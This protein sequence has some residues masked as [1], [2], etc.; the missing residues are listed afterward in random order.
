MPSIATT[1]GLIN[2]RERGSG[3]PVVMLHATLH[4]H[5]DFE[6]IFEEIAR[7]HRAVIALKDVVEAFELGPAIFIGNSVGGYAAAQLAIDDPERVAGLILV[8]SGGFT[9][10]SPATRAFIRLM[11]SPAFFTK[12]MLPLLARAYM[13]AKTPS[14]R[15]IIKRVKARAAGS[16]AAVAAKLWGSFLDPAFDLRESGRRYSRPTRAGRMQGRGSCPTASR[17]QQRRCRQPGP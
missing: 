5:R 10:Q 2:Y 16:G 17:Q 1:H 12:R 4:D 3:T 13:R 9:K 14:D 8:N 11:S 6:P 15:A 7:N